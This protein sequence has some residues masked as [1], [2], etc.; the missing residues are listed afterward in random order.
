MDR[1]VHYR[2]DWRDKGA[3]EAEP[4]IA[5]SFPCSA[6][7]M[8]RL[9]R[10]FSTRLNTPQGESSTETTREP[11][12][13]E[14]QGKPGE[15]P[16]DPLSHLSPMMRELIRTS[17]AEVAASLCTNIGSGGGSGHAPQLLRHATMAFGEPASQREFENW[18]VKLYDED[19]DEYRPPY[20]S[21]LFG[22]WYTG[23]WHISQG[24]A[25]AAY[26]ADLM[27]AYQESFGK[28]PPVAWLNA[29]CRC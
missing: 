3:W 18:L 25:F 6:P 17:T 8:R 4:Y 12:L 26:R 21:F 7:S 9:R 13:R 11:A 19:D 2:L 1:G 24:R 14:P 15:S 28:L 22:W 20:P 10:A 23:Q 16:A 27:E 29:I 5:E